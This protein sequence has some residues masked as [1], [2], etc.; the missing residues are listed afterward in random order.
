MGINIDT[1]PDANSNPNLAVK[2]GYYKFEITKAEI[3][4][5]KDPN[6]KPNLL[7]SL[8][9]TDADGKK[10]GQIL[11]RI[12]DSEAQCFAYKNAR[13]FRA[14][15]IKGLKGTVELKDLVKIVVGRKG[16]CEIINEQD[17]RFPEDKTKV[18]AKVATFGSECYWT[19]DQFAGLINPSDAVAQGVVDADDLDIPFFDPS[20]EAP[21]EVSDKEAEP[22]PT[23][24]GDGY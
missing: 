3:S 17:S 8:A 12:Y 10:A 4:I 7:M 14:T 21:A 19:I 18:Q 22:V 1:L 15:E 9:L 11:E 24:E 6:K 5:P 13:F 16:A 2:P 23:T 20:L